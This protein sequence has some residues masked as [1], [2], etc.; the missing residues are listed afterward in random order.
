MTESLGAR[1][2]EAGGNK[3][4]FEVVEGVVGGEEAAVFSKRIAATTAA[5]GTFGGGGE[6]FF[7]GADTAV[8]ERDMGGAAVAE[9]LG[10][11]NARAG[12]DAV[13]KL[14]FGDG[15][16][17]RRTHE[18]V[19]AALVFAVAK[20]RAAAGV[21]DVADL[22]GARRREGV[23]VHAEVTGVV[24]VTG[25]AVRPA[26]LGPVGLSVFERGALEHFAVRGACVV[27]PQNVLPRGVFDDG[28]GKL[29]V[30]VAG[31]G[32]R[33]DDHLA[34][35]GFACDGA[36]HFNRG[37]DAGDQRGKQDA[38]DGDDGEELGEGEAIWAF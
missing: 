7:Q 17:Q 14:G 35:V 19:R 29:V 4:L 3:K 36:R 38:D 32:V 23:Q 8:R 11:G 30:V 33:G 12:A 26:V 24:V 2:R 15:F 37:L 6:A 27:A 20:N 9:T 10:P 16:V 28:G 5:R 21:L 13:V 18:F 34:E 31:V 22:R 25:V 1:N